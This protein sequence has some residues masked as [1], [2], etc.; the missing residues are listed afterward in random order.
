[1]KTQ[2]IRISKDF[3]F[4]MAHALW[5]Y[6]GKCKDI[7]G[8]SYRLTVTIKGAVIQDKN[9]VKNGMVL[10]YGDLKNIINPL[11]ID[12]LDHALVLNG[13]SPHKKIV[14]TKD[15]PFGKVIFVPYQP[16]CENMIASFAQ[17]IIN[18]LPKELELTYLKLR[19]TQSSYAEWFIEDNS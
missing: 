9:H 16:T 2:Y 19:E 5:G 10:D 4:E 18:V 12:K 13:D 6:D 1:M 14:N 7:H 3:D 17:D 8:H 15:S 11:I